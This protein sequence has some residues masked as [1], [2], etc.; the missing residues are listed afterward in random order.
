M[1]T[2]WMSARDRRA[3]RSANTVADLGQQ[4]ARW[5]EGDLKS[6]PGYQPNYGPDDETR[7]LIPTLAALNRAG[8]LTT[9]SQ[10]GEMGPGFDGAWWCQ[11]AAVCGFVSDRALLAQLLLAAADNALLT[12]VS[13]GQETYWPEPIPVTTRN[14]EAHTVFGAHL[15]RQD[16]RTMWPAVSGGAFSAVEEAWQVA[17]IVPD[18]GA[19]GERM[20]PVL[21]TALEAVSDVAA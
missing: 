4:M 11:R 19:S 5:L 14:S 10:P 2:P 18:F 7:R 21:A 20:W 13:G 8:Y 9:C 16:L 12:V 6:W 15:G 3:W 1:R 17:I